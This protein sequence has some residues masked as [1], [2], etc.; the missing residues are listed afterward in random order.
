MSHQITYIDTREI[1][2]G[3]NDRT[4]FD[5]AS[6]DELASSIEAHGLLQPITVRWLDEANTYQ[7]IAGERRFRACKNVLSWA[8][9]PALVADVGDEEA[10]ALM[11]IEN[12]SRE[13]LD[14]IDEAMAYAAR[15]QRYGWTVEDCA[16]QAG[17]SPIRVQFRLKLLKL[18]PELQKLVRDGQ[19]PI[20]YAQILSDADLTSAHQMLAIHKLRSNPSATP[21][22]F[23]RVVGEIKE[24]QDQTAMFDLAALLAASPE[25]EQAP[26]VIEPPHPSN[27]IPPKDGDSVIEVI[28]NQV[29]FW[30]EAAEEWDRLGK[31]FKRQECIAAADALNAALFAI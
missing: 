17:V 12:V 19:L 5:Q 15:M 22:W 18:R 8:E 21:P 6:L 24:N 26:E 10:S 4:A 31:P 28:Q 25:P 9:I 3:P 20:G 2:P 29:R 27:T 23:R 13:D 14:P 16:R 30:T 1:I 7:I 11:L